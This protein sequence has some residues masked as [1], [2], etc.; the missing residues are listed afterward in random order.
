MSGKK[1]DL[2]ERL[3]EYLEDQEGEDEEEEDDDEEEGEKETEG[4]SD[5][6]D[7]GD[8]AKDGD[9]NIR[10]RTNA[11]QSMSAGGDRDFPLAD[12]KQAPQKE[13]KRMVV[14]GKQGR[15]NTFGMSL[16]LHPRGQKDDDDE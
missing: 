9:E 12:E 15:N 2:I 8:D 11:G 10:P 5:E 1:S 13:K 4:A 7:V 3:E 6:E 16:S 14:I